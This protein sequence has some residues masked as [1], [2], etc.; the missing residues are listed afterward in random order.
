MQTAEANQWQ[1]LFVFES[2]VVMGQTITRLQV[3]KHDPERVSVFLDGEFAFGLPLLEA[4]QLSK[5][6][7]LSDDDIARLRAHDEASRAYNHA[8]R[9]L[10]R[11]PYS[12]AEVRRNLGRKDYSP[13]AIDTA[14]AR[15]EDRGYLDDRAFADYW[16]ENR[17]RF[18]PRSARA[19]RYELRQRGVASATIDA[20]LH[21]FDAADAAARAAQAR[22]PRLKGLDR[23][24]FREK[25]GA[26]LGRRGFAY[27]TTRDVID[28]IISD[29]EEEDPDYFAADDSTNEE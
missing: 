27:N 16:I 2:G 17:E 29:L 14:I 22:L 4:A 12:I 18:K 11:R 9:L 5:G 25:L 7:E 24:T 8:V 28:Q 13:A 23:Q 3:Q 21:D 15:L 20:A 1:R 10:S 26:F 19:L 6:Q